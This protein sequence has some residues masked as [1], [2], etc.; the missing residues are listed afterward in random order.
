MET[1]LLKYGHVFH[2]ES[3]GKFPGTDVIEHRIVTGDAKPI[4]FLMPY[5]MR[6]NGK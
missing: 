3:D 1:V 6:W 2:N 5:A 4:G